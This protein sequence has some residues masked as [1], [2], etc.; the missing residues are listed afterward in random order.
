MTNYWIQLFIN[1]NSPTS[2]GAEENL[3]AILKKYFPGDYQLEIID[4]QEN[5]EKTEEAGIL[6]IPTLIRKW[7]KP[8]VRL[9]GALTLQTRVLTG[10]GIVVQEDK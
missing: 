6:A 5:P 2:V 8:E 10:L 3:N 7:P 1:R 9:I 4:I